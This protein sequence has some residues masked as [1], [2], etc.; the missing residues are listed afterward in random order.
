MAH[1]MVPRE[2]ITTLV[3]LGPPGFRRFIVSL[4]PSKPVQQM[5]F[6][7]DEMER[8]STHIFEGKKRGL[9]EGKEDVVEQYSRGKDILGILSELKIPGL[10]MDYKS[11]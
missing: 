2:F 9:K 3:K 4:V 7:I 5:K 11:D 10:A 1:L 8:H 6:I